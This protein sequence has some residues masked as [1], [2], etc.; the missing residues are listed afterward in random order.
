VLT[1]EE[2]KELLDLREQ[3]E[4]LRHLVKSP[5]WGLLD[6]AITAQVAVRTR[7]LGLQ[8]MNTMEETLKRNYEVGVRDGM[9][10]IPQLIRAMVES[11][12]GQYTELLEKDR[13]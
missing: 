8:P 10:S 7:A 5:G 9:Q 6:K 13:A 3:L 1:E 12:K 11:L 4:G 2:R